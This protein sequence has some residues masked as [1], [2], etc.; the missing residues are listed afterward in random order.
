MTRE[1]TDTHAPL[2]KVVSVPLPVED[3]FRIFTI[4]I[5]RW[6]P[7]RTHSVG[8]DKATTVV[9]EEGVGGRIY[10]SD[11]NGTEYEWGRVR[12]WEP[13]DRV[14]YSWYPGRDDSSAQEVEVKFTAR[15]DATEVL[16]V[17]RGWESLGNRAGVVRAE[18]ETGWDLVLGCYVDRSAS[19]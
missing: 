14:V 19:G 12:T 18:Y 17:H 15:G 3:A 16:L 7:L 4:G 13:P 8:E 9:F 5:A 6:W 10:E 2:E 11:E 1:P